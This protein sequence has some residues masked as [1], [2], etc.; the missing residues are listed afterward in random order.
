MYHISS[1]SL[2]KAADGQAMAARLGAEFVDMEMMQFHPTGILAGNSIATG[3]LLEE[4]LR[5]AG[6]HL[7]NALGERYMQRYS[8]DKLERATR[9]VVSRSSY[10]EIMAGRGTP[11]GGVLIDATHIKDV[12]KHFAGMVDRCR[13]YG[14]DLVN[15]RVEVSPSSHYHMG[16]IR[17]DV[18]C[19]TSIDGLFAAGED[20][21]GVHGANRLGGNGVADS[22]VFGARAGD[23]M[24]DYI[25]TSPGPQPPAPAIEAVC[26][27]WLQPLERNSGE[28]PF[29]L[30]DRLERVMWTKVGVVR[31]GPDMQSALPEIQEIRQRIQSAVGNGDPVYN[32]PW[33]ETINTENLSFI[34]EMLT[35]SALAREESRG[36][37]YRS[38]F[39]AQK[40]EWLKNIF[41]TPKSD[42]GF[43]M[44]QRDV[45]FTRITPQELQEHR[46]RAG[47]VTLPAIDDE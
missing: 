36:A 30:R 40:V 46:K 43:E 2:E 39:P 19:R 9:D 33:N 8:P 44:T 12:A 1:P 10:M 38:D 15:S 32:A 20:S 14:F 25:S 26:N 7:Y 23:E 41:M 29:K 37:H 4:G 16:G 13:E 5:G 28:S 11:S 27:R 24:V 6:A 45:Q 3:G 42:G 34:A 22:I 17:I 47:L 21:G 18:N 35:R 31:N